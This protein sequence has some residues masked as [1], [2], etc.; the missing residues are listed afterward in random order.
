MSFFRKFKGIHS[1]FLNKNVKR[2]NDNVW[3]PVASWSFHWTIL[4]SFMILL[5]AF[6]A[7]AVIRTMQCIVQNWFVDHV[8]AVMHP[9]SIGATMQ[10][11]TRILTRYF[12]V[13][14]RIACMPQRWI[15]VVH[16]NF[17]SNLWSTWNET[18]QQNMF[19]CIFC[20]L[21]HAVI[22]TMAI[23]NWIEIFP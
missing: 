22:E 4:N 9:S 10:R 11:A 2:T 14:H 8:C 13:R 23:H 7:R 1:F 15:H 21:W 3:N 18:F 17:V 20:L 16:W 19:T 5:C 6:P 12:N